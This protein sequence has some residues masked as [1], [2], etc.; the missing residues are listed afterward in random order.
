[1]V[2]DIALYGRLDTRGRDRADAEFPPIYGLRAAGDAAHRVYAGLSDA[3]VTHGVEMSEPDR[4]N[5]RAIDPNQGVAF[6]ASG[7]RMEMETEFWPIA[8]IQVDSADAVTFDRRVRHAP[9]DVAAFRQV[10]AKA[11]E[12]ACTHLSDVHK[13]SEGA[14]EVGWAYPDIF[15]EDQQPQAYVEMYAY[16]LG[17]SRRYTWRAD[18]LYEAMRMAE[19]DVRRWL[20]E[21]GLTNVD[22]VLDQDADPVVDDPD[23]EP[24]IGFEFAAPAD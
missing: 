22:A 18:T 14:L 5:I 3:L 2:T 15:D 4:H 12:V 10:V 24:E 23:L 9:E 6:A 8:W 20:A 21:D 16:V 17:P 19:S 13:S 11:V 1:M 7:T